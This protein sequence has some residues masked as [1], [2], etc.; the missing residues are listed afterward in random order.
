MFKKLMNLVAL[1]FLVIGFLVMLFYSID[2]FE[3]RLIVVFSIFI[4]YI[5]RKESNKEE[6]EEDYDEI[7]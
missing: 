3:W 4:F 5:C 1:F 7:I 6:E 2:S